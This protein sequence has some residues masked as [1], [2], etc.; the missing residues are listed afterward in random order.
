V[1]TE[2]NFVNDELKIND[3]L[4]D[5]QPNAAASDDAAEEPQQ[6]VD[7][8]A[9]LEA[10]QQKANEYLEGWQRSRAEFTNFRKRTDR[11][12][13]EI[14][15]RAAM[16]VLEKFLPVIDDFS[17][18]LDNTP[19]DIADHAWVNGITLINE[20]FQALLTNSGMEEINPV[21]EPFDPNF[22]EAV[23]MDQ[24]DDV[25]SGNVTVVLQKG[26]TYGDKV[27][28]SAKVRVAN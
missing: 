15:Q 14:Y 21:G 8:Q 1:H 5:S 10:A 22:H 3:E 23:G 18:A 28:R 6:E 2:S 4:Q 9:E 27:L 20:K 16:S 24:S 19:E 11:E 12:R 26:Y 25:E 7:L 17:L 13:E